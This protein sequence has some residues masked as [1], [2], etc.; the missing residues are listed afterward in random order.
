MK[1]FGITITGVSA[2]LSWEPQ[3]TILNNVYLSLIIR[4]GAFF[5]NPGLGSRL[6]LLERAKNTERT[7]RLAEEYIREALQWLLDT[8]RATKVDVQIERG[9]TRLRAA[10]AVTQADGLVVSY[11]RWIEVV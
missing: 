1:D 2:D 8:G 3:E 11:E 7:A 10:V 5:Q 4:R 6:Y 9:K